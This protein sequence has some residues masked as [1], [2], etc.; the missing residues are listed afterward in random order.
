MCPYQRGVIDD[1]LDKLFPHLPAILFDG[2]EP[3]DGRPWK[4]PAST[5]CSVR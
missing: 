2:G 1:E 3:P 4:R 5:S